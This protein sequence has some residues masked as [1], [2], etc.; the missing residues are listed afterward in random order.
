MKMNARLIPAPL[1]NIGDID[2][3]E[4]ASYVAEYNNADP[5]PRG[6]LL[7]NMAIAEAAIAL[8]K[9]I[10]YKNINVA[11][12]PKEFSHLEMTV[13]MASIAKATAAL[14]YA[15]KTGSV[16]WGVKRSNFPQKHEPGEKVVIYYTNY[17]SAIVAA[18]I[19]DYIDYQ[20]GRG[21]I[22]RLL[23]TKNSFNL[24]P[25]GWKYIGF[26]IPNYPTAQGGF[27]L[28]TED[29]QPYVTSPTV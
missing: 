2:M 8:Q 7:A 25:S 3:A 6:M 12:I 17:G 9:A 1:V 27:T 18:E 10:S 13:E 11:V 24:G 20:N 5:A 29:K 21:L 14:E 22:L 28:R 15:D 23:E 26:W 4:V 19:H 16:G